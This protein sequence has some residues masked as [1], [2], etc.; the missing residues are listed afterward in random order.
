MNE[1]LRERTIRGLECCL[2]RKC[3]ACPFHIRS[4]RDAEGRTCVYRLIE[5]ARAVV[6][7]VDAMHEDP[8]G[9]DE[10]GVDE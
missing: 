4:L 6:A 5:A 3:K 8:P 1:E 9:A 7:D 2:H 10:R